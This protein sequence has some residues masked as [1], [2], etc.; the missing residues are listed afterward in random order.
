MKTTAWIPQL[1]TP[2]LLLLRQFAAEPA[3]RDLSLP[4]AGIRQYARHAAPIGTGMLRIAVRGRL[5]KMVF[6]SIVAL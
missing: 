3:R 2:R 5:H 1:I 4:Y 6:T